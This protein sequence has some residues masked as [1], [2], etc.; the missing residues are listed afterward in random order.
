MTDQNS[1]IPEDAIRLR[2]YQIW[3]V[4][5]CPNGKALAHWLQAKAELE[6]QWRD[7]SPLSPPSFVMPRVRV[8]VPPNH[9]TAA[10]ARRDAG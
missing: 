1:V 2:S 4:E 5:G 10:K 8:S 7:P 6:A 9:R 3:Q